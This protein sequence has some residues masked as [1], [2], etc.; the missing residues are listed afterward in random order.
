MFSLLAT[1]S[2][3]MAWTATSLFFETSPSQ[4]SAQT[5]TSQKSRTWP[6]SSKSRWLSREAEKRS[7]SSD[8]SL[9]RLRLELIRKIYQRNCLCD[10]GP[11]LLFSTHFIHYHHGARFYQP[12][13]SQY[14][15]PVCRITAHATVSVGF[16]QFLSTIL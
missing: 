6:G 14:H 13:V 7:E 5:W 12:A 4:S 8:T 16:Q 10:I 11:S 1:T 3:T 2:L 9:R 15:P